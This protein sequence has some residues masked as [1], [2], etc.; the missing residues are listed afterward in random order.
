VGVKR[1][2]DLSG[3]AQV[4]LRDYLADVSGALAGFDPEQV[5]EIV[6]DLERHVLDSLH[7]DA[8]EAQ[9]AEAVA[10]LGSAAEV[11]RSAG[12]ASAATA[13]SA[14]EGRVLGVPYDIRPITAERVASRLWNPGDPRLFVPR[15]WGIGWDLNFAAVAVA[16]HLIEPDSEDEPF[17]NVP[18]GALLAALAV[19]LGLCL[20]MGASWFLFRSRFETL[21]AHFDITGHV[22]RWWP[23]WQAFA[24][25]MIMA[26]L[27][28]LWAVW[29]VFRAQK[30]GVGVVAVL[31]LSWFMTVLS[32]CVW[33]L[34]LT[35]ALG[36][37]QAP[38]RPPLYIL[39]SVLAPLFMFVVLARIGRRAEMEAQL[40]S[41]GRGGSR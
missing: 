1:I 39:G 40:G 8:D 26:A 7:P 10:A 23:A 37:P 3:A 18:V 24:L 33:L 25:P 9:T 6:E 21:P 19:P 4:V 17:A 12:A 16:L 27:P 13:N 29:R 36:A 32:V 2:E 11:A 38:W 30:S 22:D 31:G 28:T 5:A 20:A 15:I 14:G 35:T 41:A 34:E